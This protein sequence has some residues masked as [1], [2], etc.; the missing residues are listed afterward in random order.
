MGS[1]SDALYAFLS[2]EL[3]SPIGTISDLK[4][5][6]LAKYPNGFTSGVGAKIAHPFFSTRWYSYD[7]QISGDT[8]TVPTLGTLILAPFIVPVKTSFTDIGVEVT[9]AGT[10]GATVELVVYQ[11]NANGSLTKLSQKTVAADAIGTPSQ[12]NALT[13][14]PGT[15]FLGSVSFSPTTAA[16]LR[17][18]TIASLLGHASLASANAATVNVTGLASAAFVPVTINAPLP[19][20]QSAILPK[21][22]LKVA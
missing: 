14:E 1:N 5:A 3:G 13:L 6:F 11:Y 10:A 19:I 21:V 7:N 15:Y 20:G 12:A 2:A 18:R 17:A 9:V 22:M 8:T 4:A 16:T